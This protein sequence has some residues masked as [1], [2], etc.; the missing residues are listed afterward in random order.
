MTEKLTSRRFNTMPTEERVRL[1]ALSG[2]K[3]REL[4]ETKLFFLKRE[5]KISDD[6]IRSVLVLMRD[7]GSANALLPVVEKLKDKYNLSFITDGVASDYLQKQG[8][9]LVDKTPAEGLLAASIGDDDTNEY[10][11]LDTE[12]FNP[13]LVLTTNTSSDSGIENFARA[14]FT[15]TPLVLVEDIYET[16]RDFIGRGEKVKDAG[17]HMREADKI[18]VIDETAKQKILRDFGDSIEGLENKIEITGQPSFDKMYYEDRE[19]ISNR[20]REGLKIGRDDKFI[21][22]FGVDRDMKK[23]LETIANGIKLTTSGGIKFL[24]RTHPRDPISAEDYEEYNKIITSAGIEQVDASK[25]AEYT[26]DEINIASDMVITTTSTVTFESIY[27]N[28]PVINI[29]AQEPSEYIAAIDNAINNGA[30]LEVSD[31]SKFADAFKKLF[32]NEGGSVDKM[33][34]NQ[35]KFFPLDGKNAERVADVIEKVI[36]SVKTE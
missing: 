27:R 23:E 18:C 20:V 1:A 19:G 34:K 10:S 32:Y 3:A 15:D 33:I 28:K 31:F 17:V 5:G 7:P 9:D 8:L 21:V 22:F 24:L 12:H 2:E 4:F 25:A 29:T 35:K 6:E 13:D 30:S 11:P 14:T 36:T 16:A 26:T